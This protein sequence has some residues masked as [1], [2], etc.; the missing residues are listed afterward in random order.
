M[1]CGFFDAAVRVCCVALRFVAGFFLVLVVAGRAGGAVMAVCIA[2]SFVAA[3]VSSS[4]AH[5]RHSVRTSFP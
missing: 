1:E 5:F 2:A 4:V 3:A